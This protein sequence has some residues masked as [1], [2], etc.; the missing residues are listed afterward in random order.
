MLQAAGKVFTPDGFPPEEELEAGGSGGHKRRSTCSGEEIRLL[1]IQPHGLA[2]T[3]T[4]LN[5][6]RERERIKNKTKTKKKSL[7][8]S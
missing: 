5:S 3:L 4:K 1:G 2:T 7:T 6:R 8:N